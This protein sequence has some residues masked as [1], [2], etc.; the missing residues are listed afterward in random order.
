[1]IAASDCSNPE[2]EK[3]SWL[4]VLIRTFEQEHDWANDEDQ[5]ASR[6]MV[7]VVRGLA[8][9]LECRQIQAEEG[10]RPRNKLLG[11][12]AADLVYYAEKGRDPG[13]FLKAVLANDL[14]GA[15]GRADPVNLVLLPA[16][17]RYVRNHLP[18][19]CWGSAERVKDW[20]W[21]KQTSAEKES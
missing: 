15:L 3:L 1:M 8:D 10:V 17:G 13:D 21:A 9:E 20:L 18:A 6:E 12:I 19:I 7:D 5:A 16:I 2:R 4:T 14:Q 11:E